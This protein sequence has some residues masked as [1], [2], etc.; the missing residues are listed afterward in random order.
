MTYLEIDRAMID[1]TRQKCAECKARLDAIPKQ[2][3]TER[4]AVQLEYGIY[5]FC[6]NAGLLF[7]S[8]RNQTLQ[9]RRRFLDS[10]IDQY[11]KPGKIYQ[12]I[13]EDEKLRF[14]A[15]LQAELFLRDQWLGIQYDELAAAQTSKDTDRAFELKIK[16]GA[17]EN[18]F[19]A[20]EVWRKENNVYPAV[21]EENK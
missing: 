5:T 21:F 11:P 3:T 19:A 14:A 8:A 13:G 4:K 12:A 18:M 10:V 7:T 1:I 6:G 20:W 15:A 16:I 2:N 17:A 9:T